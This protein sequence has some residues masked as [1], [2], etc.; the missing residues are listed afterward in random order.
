MNVLIR[1]VLTEKSTKIAEGGRYTF[2]VDKEKDKNQIRKTVE[3]MFGVKV[4]RLWTTK[5]EGKHK[6]FG[7]FYKKL[8]QRKKVI[9]QLKEGQT[10]DLFE[11]KK[12]TK[13]GGKNKI[14][15]G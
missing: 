4:I 11:T 3:E 1:P 10:I 5:M 7:R 8:G 12:K 13:K 2:Y 15:K 14:L 9:V 6:K